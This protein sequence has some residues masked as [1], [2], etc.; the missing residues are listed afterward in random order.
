[1][2]PPSKPLVPGGARH[3]PINRQKP[4]GGER[5]RTVLKLRYLTSNGGA[6]SGGASP[7]GGGASPNDDGASPNDVSASPSDDG[8]SPRDVS[9]SPSDGVP[10]PDVVL[11]RRG[12]DL[13][14]ARRAPPRASDFP[15]H[16]R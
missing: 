9:A 14:R 13:L 8:A 6:S 4:G 1:V 12:P 10:S 15:P 5:T 2:R 11:V 16:R 3:I 7:N